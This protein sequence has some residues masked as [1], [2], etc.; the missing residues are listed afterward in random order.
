MKHVQ[1]AV[2]ALA[3]VLLAGCTSTPAAPRAGTA[4]AAGT[5]PGA[6][7]GAPVPVPGE[8]AALERR[9]GARIG[10]YAVDT[11]TGRTL[12]HRADERFAYASTCKALAA[13]ALLAATSDADLD[14][15]VR[16]R[17]ADLVSYSPVTE[18]YVGSGMTLRAVA[19]AAVR[20]SDNTAGNLMFA[21]LGGPAGFERALRGVGDRVTDPARTEPDLNEAAPGDVRDTSTPRALVGSLRAYALGD[22]L[23]PPDRAVLLDWMRSSTTGAGLVRAGAPAGWRVADKSGT[24][25]YGTRNDIAV[26][27]PPDA[28]P[29][30]LAVLT[31]RADRHATPDD[32]LVAGAAAATL[33]AMR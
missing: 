16:Y 30:V 18:R 7:T 15:V 17:R 22:V 27:W 11:G 23:P 26:V 4:P 21:E 33:A 24:G 19:E 2:A 20:Q 6:S 10:V 9:F 14:R 25:G 31:T 28:A 29:I 3:I 1:R 8:L 32:A 12:A 13:G 5:A